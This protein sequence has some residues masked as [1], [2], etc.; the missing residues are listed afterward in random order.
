MKIIHMFNHEWYFSTFDKEPFSSFRT[1]PIAVRQETL[2]PKSK[3]FPTPKLSQKFDCGLQVEIILLAICLREDLRC[4]HHL[5]KVPVQDPFVC[6]C[7]LYNPFP[8]AA[9]CLDGFDLFHAEVWPQ[10]RD[11]DED[12]EQR[13]LPEKR[14]PPF[15]RELLPDHP[16]RVADGHEM[17]VV[18]VERLF[19]VA[20]AEGQQQ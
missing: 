12:G 14:H 2:Y 17:H 10:L 20:V 3:A 7:R 19:R 16:Q 18:E 9:L 13:V 15:G 8:P 5:E 4:A 1:I 6:Q 11:V